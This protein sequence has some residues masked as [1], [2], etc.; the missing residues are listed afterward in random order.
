MSIVYNNP[1]TALLFSYYAGGL[2]DWTLDPEMKKHL[3]WYTDE[4]WLVES[5]EQAQPSDIVKPKPLLRMKLQV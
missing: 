3:C 5:P 2:A 1:S 4:L